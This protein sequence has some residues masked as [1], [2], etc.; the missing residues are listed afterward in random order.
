MPEVAAAVLPSKERRWLLKHTVECFVWRQPLPSEH[1]DEA[2]APLETVALAVG[3]VGR[4][5]GCKPSFKEV[6]D[7][8]CEAG[9]EDLAWRLA[10]V[11][12]LRRA[13]AHPDVLLEVDLRRVLGCEPAGGDGLHPHVLRPKH[14]H[15]AGEFE[16]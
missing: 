10:A 4:R 11:N 15:K 3:L 8:L 6:V 14:H 13:R 5:T 1:V 16:G 9:E 7:Y 2:A 12:K